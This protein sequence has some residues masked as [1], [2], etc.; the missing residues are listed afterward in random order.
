MSRRIRRIVLCVI[1]SLLLYGCASDGYG[2][3][4]AAPLETTGA[5]SAGDPLCFPGLSW[6]MTREEVISAL[7]MTAADTQSKNFV[8]F[9]AG[10]VHEMNRTLAELQE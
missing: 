7:A 5:A 1:V 8:L 9:F 4:T 2:N 10:R 3:T 6:D